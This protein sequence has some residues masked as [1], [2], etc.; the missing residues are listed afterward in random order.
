MHSTYVLIDTTL[1]GDLHNKPWLQ[2]NRRPS[3]IAAIYGRYAIDVSPVVVDVQRAVQCSR[4]F[5]LMNIVNARRPQL[6]ISFIETTLTLEKLV[7]HLRQ[8]I[9]VL[10]RG[11]VE[12]TL[13]FAD[14]VVLPTLASILTPEQWALMTAPLKSWKVHGRDGNLLS[15]PMGN[16]PSSIKPPLML[17]GAQLRALKDSMGTDQL[18][19]NLRMYR[20]APSSTYLTAEAFAHATEARRMWHAAGHSDDQDL[21]LF[22]AGVFD[23]D[24]RLLRASGI[25]ETLAG[26]ERTKIRETLQRMVELNTTA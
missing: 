20:S 17:T 11:N 25:E 15:L 22:A 24:G 2:K 13:R 16:A 8:F 14:G 18:L 26:S 19:V 1:L 5:S 21:V 6:G 23:T 10:T 4:I 3:W 12:L 7:E 9:C